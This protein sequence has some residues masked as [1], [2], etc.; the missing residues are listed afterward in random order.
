MYQYFHG[1]VKFIHKN[2]EMYNIIVMCNLHLDFSKFMKIYM[3]MG[4][5]NSCI[6]RVWCFKIVGNYVIEP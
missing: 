4:I 3:L 5:N 1:S 6:M 2:E